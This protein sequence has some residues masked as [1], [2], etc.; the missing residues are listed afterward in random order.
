MTLQGYIDESGTMARDEVLA[1]GLVLCSGKKKAERVHFKVSQKLFPYL[2]NKPKLLSARDLHFCRMSEAFI[3]QTAIILKDEPIQAF[4]TYRYH[5][6]EPDSFGRLMQHYK[7]MV[8]QVIYQ[9][10][11]HTSEDL[12][13]VLGDMGQKRKFEKDLCAEIESVAELFSARHNGVFRKVSCSIASA[14]VKGIQLAD[15]YTGSTR[16]MILQLGREREAG[17][18]APF[19]HLDKQ[20]AHDWAW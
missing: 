2:V 15:F 9:A 8:K 6:E 7:T 1:I 14:R 13:I 20:I 10:L 5:D 17:T 11:E 18:S 3:E 12:E 4:V 16:R 19:N